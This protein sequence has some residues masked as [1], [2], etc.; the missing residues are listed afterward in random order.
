MKLNS[1]L[2][3]SV[4]FNSSV[5]EITYRVEKPRDLGKAY[6]SCHALWDQILVSHWLYPGLAPATAVE[7][8]LTVLQ[9]LVKCSLLKHCAYI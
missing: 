5:G 6:A 3:F 2:C 8:T 1:P 4:V 7:L 9:C